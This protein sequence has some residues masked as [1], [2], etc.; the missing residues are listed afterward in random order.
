MGK[1]VELAK[2]YKTQLILTAIVIIGFLL[3][4]ITID[5][6]DGLWCDEAYSWWVSTL[7]FPFEI[8]E[9]LERN[10][11]H[12]PL[13]HFMLHFWMKLFGDSDVTIRLL[14]VLFSTG[15]II[16]SYFIGKKL[17]DENCG[18]ICAALNAFLLFNL[19]HAKEI[20]FYTP[21]VTFAALSL[22]FTIKVFD[23]EKIT[24]PLIGL[25]ISNALLIY[26]L[27]TGAFFVAIANFI[28][29]IFLVIYKRD[30][31]EEF[32]LSQLAMFFIC[33]PQ[34]FFM[35]SQFLRSRSSDPWT[36]MPLD[37]FLI[38]E[39]TRKAFMFQ[40]NEF[41]GGM[42]TFLAVVLLVAILTALFK[43]FFSRNQKFWLMLLIFCSY[44]A[45]LFTTTYFKIMPLGF[46]YIGIFIM[47][48]M[49]VISFLIT[50]YK[51]NFASV[52]FCAIF[53]IEIYF[54]Y[55][56]HAMDHEL[57]AFSKTYGYKWVATFIEEEGY[58]KDA[59]INMGWG[60][61]TARYLGNGAKI[62]TGDNTI[63]KIPVGSHFIIVAS[64]DFENN[65]SAEK[66]N[67]K[68]YNDMK[69]DERFKKVLISEDLSEKEQKKRLGIY[70]L[71]IFER[72]E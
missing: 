46:N 39:Y 6:P 42:F 63:D 36:N 71:A 58:G 28:L 59:L 10:D 29:L 27:T 5:S 34:M 66:R 61:R 18:L 68:L 4:L 22:L 3:R 53:L 51:Y 25:V 64:T 21:S 54:G 43:I 12:P 11:Y 55:W 62:L 14:S 9:E 45:F 38:F 48:F 72:I 15:T 40:L 37:P 23:E 20:R 49:L 19:I 57:G 13:Y 16:V 52:L 67:L 70:K 60:E 65:E 26:T 2:K 30:K 32:L 31:I 35:F 44:F 56:A 7:S 47:M 41:Y 17:K 1:V 8:I 33:T 24:K 50:E 69:N